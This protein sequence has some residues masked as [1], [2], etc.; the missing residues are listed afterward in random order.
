VFGAVGLIVGP[1]A[2]SLFVAVV[3]RPARESAD[4]EKLQV[5]ANDPPEVPH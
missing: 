2:V 3:E 1:L 4:A 5:A